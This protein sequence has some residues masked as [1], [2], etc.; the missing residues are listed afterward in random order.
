MAP[1]VATRRPSRRTWRRVAALGALVVIIFCG[2]TVSG[3]LTATDLAGGTESIRLA[4]ETF[5]NGLGDLV[6]VDNHRLVLQAADEN[7]KG[8]TAPGV[9]AASS[10]YPDVGTALIQDN[11]SYVFDMHEVAA[12]NWQ[13]GDDFTIQV[14][15]FDGV[16]STL[17]GTLYSKQDTAEAGDIEGVMVSIDSGST[18]QYAIT[19]NI[20]I[21]RQ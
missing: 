11:Y 3:A 19:F 4:R 2:V 9:E 14:Y 17:L 13:V 15:G 21:S 1:T 18:D 6:D 16:D 20:V 10:G 5:V 12:D 8:D 7:A